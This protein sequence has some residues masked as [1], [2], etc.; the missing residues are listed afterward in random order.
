M[1]AGS[2]A[3]AGVTGWPGGVSVGRLVEGGGTAAAAP[4]V[5]MGLAC[6]T[7]RGKGLTE[8]YRWQLGVE[9]M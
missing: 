5:W 1:G 7:R 2:V 9:S 6:L 3:A 4:E 8:L